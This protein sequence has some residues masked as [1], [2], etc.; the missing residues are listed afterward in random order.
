MKPSLADPSSLPPATLRFYRT[1]L[2][3]LRQSGPP[4]LVG[5]A[6][7]YACY[8]GIVRHTKDLDLFVRPADVRAALDVLAAVGCRTEITFTHWLGKAFHDDDFIDLIY[9]SGNGLCPVDDAWFAHAVPHTVLGRAALLCAPEEMIW[10]KAFIQERERFDGAD[11]AHLIRARGRTLDW[12][13][14]LDRFGPHWRV[15]FGQVVL[16]GYIYPDEQDC[17]PAAVLGELTARWQAEMVAPP[18]ADRDCRGVLLSRMQYVSDMERE[19]YR[20]PRLPPLGGMSA[21]E[22]KVWTDAAFGH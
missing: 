12:R 17:I 5:G 7:A 2:E 8:T 21:E 20:D 13:R 15:L 11:V 1:T 9:S 14:L 4:F 6:Y 22:V 18:T 19:G 10:Q 16:F 3:V